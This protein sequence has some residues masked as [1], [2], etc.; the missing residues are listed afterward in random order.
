V[1]A[2]GIEPTSAVRPMAVGAIT[3]AAALHA[4][5]CFVPVPGLTRAAL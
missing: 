5:L 2:A 3:H 4:A 1:E